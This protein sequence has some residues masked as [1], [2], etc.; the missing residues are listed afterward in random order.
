MTGT[1]SARPARLLRFGRTT[2]GLREG[3]ARRAMRLA[4]AADLYAGG[5]EPAFGVPLGGI[6]DAV[7]AAADRLA[8]IGGRARATAD[9]FSRADGRNAGDYVDWV[10]DPV[11]HATET[12][13]G[14][15]LGTEHAVP[16]AVPW[17]KVPRSGGGRGDSEIDRILDQGD[18]VGAAR[19][20]Y[21]RFL[22]T[23]DAA[24]ASKAI[25]GTVT[26]VGFGISALQA[27]RSDTEHQTGD[28]VRRSLIR[29][30]FT[31]GGSAIGTAAGAEGAAAV[32]VVSGVAAGAA[33]LCG[34][35]GGFLGAVGGGWVL[36]RLAD[37][38]DPEPPVSRDP[39]VL[40]KRIED[41]MGDKNRRYVSVSAG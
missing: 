30:T 15:D 6:A 22:E 21:D 28:R 26:V 5:T 1:A 7:A 3:L 33:P 20:A 39:K 2:T 25:V 41:P 23:I 40:S 27:Y 18:K 14:C 19:S 17:P 34:A 11:F 12:W 35:V 36:G 4:M 10:D 8:A 24:A 31:T 38:L 13:F 32:C 37:A 29:A 9:A 16:P